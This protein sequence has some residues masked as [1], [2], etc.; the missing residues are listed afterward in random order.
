MAKK[1]AAAGVAHI[2]TSEKTENGD[3]IE[4]PPKSE[5]VVPPKLFDVPCTVGVN[6]SQTIP[7]GNYASFKIGVLLTVP[8]EPQD[9]DET[10]EFVSEWV[11]QKLSEMSEAINDAYGIGD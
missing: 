11:G 5:E 4:Q 7:V 10:F 3:V 8:S 9:I 1:I 6:A 2:T